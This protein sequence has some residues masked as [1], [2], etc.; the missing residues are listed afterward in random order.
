METAL[1]AGAGG[2]SVT[3]TRFNR[4]L[5]HLGWVLMPTVTVNGVRLFYE[6]TG[7]G[8]PLLLVHGSWVDHASWNL[9]VPALAQRFPVLTY[10]RR[11]H[12]QSER[13]PT[14]GSAEEDIADLA[15]LIEHLGLAPSHVAGNSFG[16][17]L[18]LRLAAQHPEVVRSVAA[19]EPP[20]LALLFDDPDHGLAVGV[21][22]TLAVWL[23]CH[24][25]EPQTRVWQDRISRHAKAEMR[26]DWHDTRGG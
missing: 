5:P 25:P 16:G 10:D 2:C 12:S 11:G 14:Q 9:V 23:A 21:R 17:S 26:V 13:P 7:D 8:P 22:S 20:F 6:L 24:H 19:H 1:R 15:A 3:A 4:S 18:A